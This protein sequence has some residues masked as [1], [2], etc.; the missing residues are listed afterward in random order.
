LIEKK[1]QKICLKSENRKT[2][3]KLKLIS[4]EEAI[5]FYEENLKKY[6]N[7]V[8]METYSKKQINDEFDDLFF[9]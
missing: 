2:T 7:Y 3:F 9:A 1:F 6:S 8:F 4:T 5:K